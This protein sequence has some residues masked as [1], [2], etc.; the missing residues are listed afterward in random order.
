MN[1]SAQCI[2]SPVM[3]NRA[4]AISMQGRVYPPGC[5]RQS[6]LDRSV[7]PHRYRRTDS[8]FGISAQASGCVRG[9]NLPTMSSELGRECKPTIVKSVI[10]IRNDD[11]DEP[12]AE[13]DQP[14][15]PPPPS[16]SASRSAPLQISQRR[17]RE[18][19]A[20]QSQEQEFAT[21]SPEI[22]NGITAPIGWHG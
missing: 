1:C 13:F 12:V 15:S 17:R 5:R 3:S 4:E 14:V 8:V 20:A 6:S 9:E 21:G 22:C 2:R 16:I 7:K 19:L 18:I 11:I 10:A